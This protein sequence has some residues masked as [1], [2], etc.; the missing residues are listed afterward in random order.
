M[1]M[2]LQELFNPERIYIDI[3]AQDK[4]GVLNE[5]VDFLVKVYHL[6]NKEEI[7]AKIW[8]REEKMSTGLKDG[9]AFPHGKLEQLHCCYGVLGVS[10]QGVDFEA[11]NG[12]PVHVIFLLVDSVHDVVQHLLVLQR[13]AQ[14]VKI[15]DFYQE[16]LATHTP[17]EA[18]RVIKKFETSF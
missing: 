16:L 13:M 5:L 17:D 4:P 9:F 18:H 7:L 2:L 6:N 14:L 1:S 11:L 8:A 10:R 15:P 3:K 12:E